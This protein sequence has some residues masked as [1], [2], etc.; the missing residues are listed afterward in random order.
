MISA[1]G[2]TSCYKFTDAMKASL[3]ILLSLS[4]RSTSFP[5]QDVPGFISDYGSL[6]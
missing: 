3:I 2:T 4:Y 6:V 5:E 1:F